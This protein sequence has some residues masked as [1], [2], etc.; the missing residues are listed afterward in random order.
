MHR[1]GVYRKGINVMNKTITV[2]IP[3]YNAGRYLAHCL[4]SIVQNSYRNLEIICINDGSTDNSLTLLYDFQKRDHRI[5][6]INQEN[7]GVAV[8]RNVGMLHATGEFI[9]FVDAD[10]YVHPMYFELLIKEMLR[11]NSDVVIGDL[12]RVSD[13]RHEFEIPSSEEIVS[14]KLPYDEYLECHLKN[15][16]YGEGCIG[17][18]SLKD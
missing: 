2:I 14:R 3:V 6:V 15:P 4:E 9:S 8:A 7:A 16:V 5:V 17:I 18:Q 10:D 11:Y 12:L 13:E 1:Y